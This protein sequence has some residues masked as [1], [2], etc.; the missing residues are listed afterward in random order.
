MAEH[1]LLQEMKLM[2]DHYKITKNISDL[3][4]VLVY[5]DGYIIVFSFKQ[6]LN[7]IK[8]KN[9]YTK[10]NSYNSKRIMENNFV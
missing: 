10:K 5:E 7:V 1:G 8:E 9:S 4:V 2:Q 3:K 6:N